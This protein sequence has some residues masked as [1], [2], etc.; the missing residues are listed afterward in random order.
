MATGGRKDKEDAV[1]VCASAVI[2]SA[3]RIAILLRPINIGAS[4]SGKTK[5]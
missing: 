4:T 2:V 3:L 5:G 1:G